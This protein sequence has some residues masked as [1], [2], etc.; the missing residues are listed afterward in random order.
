MDQGTKQIYAMK[1]M[2]K[3]RLKKIFV[4]KN[5][6]AYSAVETEIAILKK[7]VLPSHLTFI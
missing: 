3:L 4:G 7:M 5:K 2:D 6:V 1:I